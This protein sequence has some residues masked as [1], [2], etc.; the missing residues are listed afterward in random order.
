MVSRVGVYVD[1]E[2][3]VV[4][5]QQE[6]DEEVV[7][8]LQSDVLERI[9]LKHLTG[10]VIDLSGTSVL[11]TFLARKLFDTCRMARLIGARPI[12]SGMSAGMAISLIDLDFNP[13]DVETAVTLE[14][15]LLRLRD[16]PKFD[17]IAQSDDDFDAEGDSFENLVKG[18]DVIDGDTEPKADDPD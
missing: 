13:G 6:L 9:S 7:K 1:G 12:I 10:L 16:T 4:P 2:N 11:D 18:S 15:G 3:L 14:D 17:L 8:Q 5:I